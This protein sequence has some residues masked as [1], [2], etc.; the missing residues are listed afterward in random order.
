MGFRRFRGKDPTLSLSAFYLDPFQI[1][2]RENGHWHSHVYKFKDIPNTFG[3][4]IQ[5]WITFILSKK[6]ERNL[7]LCFSRNHYPRGIGTLSKSTLQIPST[8]TDAAPM[9][10]RSAKVYSNLLQSL[11]EIIQN[12]HFASHLFF[13][14]KYFT[15]IKLGIL[16]LN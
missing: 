13:Q 4:H 12:T 6:F 16:R 5:N 2:I 14:T 1:H 10:G 11:A 8:V 7:E 9:A 3:F 15:I